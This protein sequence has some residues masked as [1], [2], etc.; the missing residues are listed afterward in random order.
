MHRIVFVAVPPVMAFDLA[1]AQMVLGA[2][3]VDGRPGYAVRV[4]SAEPGPVETVGGPPLLTELGLDAAAGA[5]TVVVIGGGGR[6]DVDPRVLRTVRDAHAAGRRVAGICTGTFVLARAGVLD[7]RRATTHW[8]LTGDLARR[9]PAVRVEPDVLYVADGPVVTSAGAAAG[10]ELCL[11]LVREDHGAA[12][13]AEAARGTVAA[14]P[15]PA[16]QPQTVRTPFPPD[17]DAS[18]A[19]TRA[20]ALERLDEPL[21]LAVLAAHANMSTRTLTRR[22][23]DETGQSPLQWLLHQRLA[24]ARELLERTDLPMD[25]VARRSGLGGADSLR[26]HMVRRLGVTPSAYRAGRAV[27]GSV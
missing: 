10:V 21:T 25:Q 13:A 11:H 8:G 22:F 1:I 2:A 20:W 5:D 23:H 14:P 9:F 15:R 27:A 19:A 18:L 4:C 17:R 24:R 16:D 3:A 12:V 6:E 7:G 26:A